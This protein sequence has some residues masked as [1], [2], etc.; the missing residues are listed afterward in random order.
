MTERRKGFEILLQEELFTLEREESEILEKL[1][2]LQD[3]LKAVKRQKETVLGG[4]EEGFETLEEVLASQRATSLRAIEA[5]EEARREAK[6]VLKARLESSNEVY[7]SVFVKKTENGR[8]CGRYLFVIN[9]EELLEEC[10][11]ASLFISHLENHLR[12]GREWID[13]AEAPISS[14]TELPMKFGINMMDMF[15]STSW[16]VAVRE[17]IGGFH[18]YV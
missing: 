9:D 18:K 3:A 13:D 11:D 7:F 1:Q 15:M 8:Y 17:E 16:M 14:F 12:W 4:L 2:S 6:D 10:L 5:H